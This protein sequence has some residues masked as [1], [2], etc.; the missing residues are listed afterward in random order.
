MDAVERAVEEI[1][2]CLEEAK[3][4][5]K[6]ELRDYPQ[7][8][9]ACDAQYNHLAE[10]RRQVS[11]TLARLEAID[12]EDASIADSARAIDALIQS[13]PHIDNEVARKIG[14]VLKHDAAV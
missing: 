2:R 1:K 8:I 5:I 10:E 6:A 14:A 9:T 4:S 12:R 7:P 13:S 3:A 11:R